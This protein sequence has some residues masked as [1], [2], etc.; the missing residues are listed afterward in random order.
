[1]EEISKVKEELPKSYQVINIERIDDFIFVQTQE[2]SFLIDKNKKVY[3]VG[4]YSHACK[5]YH[6]GKDIFAVLEDS[7]KQDLVNIANREVYLSHRASYYSGIWKI[8]DDYVHISGPDYEESP[9]FN[10]RTKKFIKPDLEVPVKYGWK[11]A[12]NLFVYENNDYGKGIYQKFIIN[13]NGEVFYNCG[14]YFPYYE[15]GNIILSSSKDDEVIVVHDVLNGAA[16]SEMLSRSDAIKSNPLVYTADGGHAKSIC[17]VSGKEFLVVDFNM[18]ILKKYNLDIDSGNAKYKGTGK[19]DENVKGYYGTMEFSTSN[20]WN[21]DVST[22]KF[23][24]NENS[25]LNKYIMNY[26]KELENNDI[27]LDV[28]LMSFEQAKKLGCNKEMNYS[29][30]CSNAPEWVY[31]TSYWL[32]SASGLNNVYVI[33]NTSDEKFMADYKYDNNWSFGIRPIIK[34]STSK[35]K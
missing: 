15:D 29:Y 1:M 32:G 20:Y 35:V 10:I 6:M 12:P 17:F 34:V 4:N 7:Y 9:L 31:S 16:K 3:D 23:V 27:N 33:A 18:N 11:L 22:P 13:Q 24:Y 2:K 8:D 14:S 28:S 21:E 19:Q 25:S 26:K 30:D 5:I